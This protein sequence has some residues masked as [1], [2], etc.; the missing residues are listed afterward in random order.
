MLNIELDLL[1]D[2]DLDLDLDL[3]IDL[4]LDLD[5]DLG[6]DLELDN[7]NKLKERCVLWILKENCDL[8]NVCIVHTGLGLW[9]HFSW[10]KSQPF[11]AFLIIISHVILV[12]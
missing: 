11:H 8:S 6:A 10:L 1:M 7:I 9:T 2:I 5:L 12:D 4:D 3:D